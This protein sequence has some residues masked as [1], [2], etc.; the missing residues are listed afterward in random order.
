MSSLEPATRERLE[1]ETRVLA[2][3]LRLSLEYGDSEG[4]SLAHEQIFRLLKACQ[5]IGESESLA[6]PSSQA[7]ADLP[8]VLPSIDKGRRMPDIDWFAP[9][10][11]ESASGNNGP[12]TTAQNATP[13][14]INAPVPVPAESGVAAKPAIELV[15]SR[16]LSAELEDSIDSLYDL[17]GAPHNATSGGIHL[18]FLF[19]VRRIMRYIQAHPELRGV[20]RKTVLKRL[21]S[22][23]IAHDIL[24]DSQTRAS[25]DE[26]MSGSSEEDDD[27]DDT[28]SSTVNTR[29]PM[30]IG[31]LLQSSGLLEKTELEIAADMH[32]AMPELM[33]GAFLVKQGFVKEDDLE[34]VLI[35][36]TLIKSGELDLGQ[37]QKVMETRA[38]DTSIKLSQLL[39]ETGLV[40]PQRIAEVLITL[41]VEEVGLSDLAPKKEAVHVPPPPKDPVSINLKNAIPSW[42]DQLDWNAPEEESSEPAPQTAPVLLPPVADH[43]HAVPGDVDTS[44]VAPSTQADGAGQ[45]MTSEIGTQTGEVSAVGTQTGEV[46]ALVQPVITS[47]AAA[48]EDKQSLYDTAQLKPITE[49]ESETEPVPY[50]AAQYEITS[51]N[52]VITD[53]EVIVEKAEQQE[54]EVFDA[55][56]S[57]SGDITPGAA[58]SAPVLPLDQAPDEPR[59]ARKHSLLDLMVDLVTPELK[60]EAEEPGT[61]P[62]LS[63][64][65]GDKESGDLDTVLFGPAE[66]PSD[67]NEVLSDDFEMLR[68]AVDISSVMPSH[69]GSQSATTG[70]QPVL[71]EQEDVQDPQAAPG[72]LPAGSVASRPAKVE[73]AEDV[74]FGEEDDVNDVVHLDLAVDEILDLPDPGDVAASEAAALAAAA[75]DTKIDSWSIVSMPASYLASYLLDEEEP[76]ANN[77]GT[78]NGATSG[79]A[80]SGKK[81]LEPPEDRERGKFRRRR[82]R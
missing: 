1:L 62:L 58:N 14:D 8:L 40:T 63:T 48:P 27:T 38:Q 16:S 33:F 61:E 26:R 34:C 76:V 2:A 42:K 23:W 37:F 32:K 65:L 35:G 72:T 25:Y 31:E 79:T 39:V 64:V 49:D 24:S 10:Q 67:H 45:E 43:A 54:V 11:E 51:E 68:D 74:F 21:Q 28:V 18:R 73:T 81:H 3:A 53:D 9:A 55:T 47:G 59:K 41:P 19:K 7:S 52:P 69:R 4:S 15:K 30:R 12:D 29:P 60:D 80:N 6:L 36:Q 5:E 70:P 50:N 46:N 66:P 22:Y 77:K 56:D 75:K 44:A 57:T 71:S 82:G 78:T 17:L 13:V 20:E